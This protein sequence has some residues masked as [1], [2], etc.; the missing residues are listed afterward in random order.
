MPRWSRGCSR[1]SGC[2]AD[3][4]RQDAEHAAVLWRRGSGLSLA[5]RLCLAFGRRLGLR[6]ATT[7][8]RW[9]GLPDAPDLLLIR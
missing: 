3:V 1:H 6:V 2:V 5:D 7:N 8:R 9:Q 4:T